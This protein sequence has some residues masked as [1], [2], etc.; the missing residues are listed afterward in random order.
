MGHIGKNE[1]II[2]LSRIK[3]GF[4]DKS[5][6]GGYRDIKLNVIYHSPINPKLNMIC[7]IQLILGQYLHEK[8]RI[9]KL[10]RYFCIF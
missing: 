10:Y 4:L 9:H 7:E 2:E 5:F 1:S 8:K 6:A 3:N